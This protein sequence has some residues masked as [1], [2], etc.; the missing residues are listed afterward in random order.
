V[1]A[2]R[3]GSAGG[4]SGAPFYYLDSIS[5]EVSDRYVRLS[6]NGCGCGCGCG[7]VCLGDL[8]EECASNVDALAQRI[9]VMPD[10]E[11]S[12]TVGRAN[13]RAAR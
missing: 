3:S 2:L 8:V 11:R 6:A 13:L 5:V 1:R 9:R 7:C 12:T 4:R 10:T